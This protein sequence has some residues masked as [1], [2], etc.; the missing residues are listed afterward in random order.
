[1]AQATAPILDST[2]TDIPLW[3]PYVRCWGNNRSRVSGASGQLLTQA[4]GKLRCPTCVENFHLDLVDVGVDCTDNF[5]RK[6]AIEKIILRILRLSAFSH[7][8][9]PKRT[10]RLST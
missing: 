2:E 7:S 6:K 8:L 10:F 5:F 4:V 3:S 1:M 9:D